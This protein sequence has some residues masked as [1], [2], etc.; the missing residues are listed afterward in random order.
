MPGSSRLESL[1]LGCISTASN[2]SSRGGLQQRECRFGRR[3]LDVEPSGEMLVR[4]H[5]RHAV[6][7]RGDGAIGGTG[8]DGDGVGLAALLIAPTLIDPGEGDQL[9]LAR[10]KQERT[11][12]TLG[13]GPLVEAVGDDQAA[14]IAHG[15]AKRRLVQHFLRRAH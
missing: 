14:A 13:P 6:V 1:I 4:Q 7:Q 3:R 8:E 11:P 12:L 15:V 10:A 5:D 9:R 2:R